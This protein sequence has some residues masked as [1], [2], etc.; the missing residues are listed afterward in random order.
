MPSYLI[1]TPLRIAP[2]KTLKPGEIHD[3]KVAQAKELENIG[4]VVRVVQNPVSRASQGKQNTR[5]H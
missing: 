2:G 4:A 3:M 1:K 5:K